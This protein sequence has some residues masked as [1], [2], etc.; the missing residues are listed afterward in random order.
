MELID[1]STEQTTATTD[2]ILAVIALIAAIYLKRIGKQKPW[3]ITLW[4]WAFYLFFLAAL[5]GAIVHGF[6]MSDE[7]SALLWHSLYLALGLFVAL[8]V[9]GCI[10]DIWGKFIAKRMLLIMLA[11]GVGFYVL[12]LI[13]SDSFIVFIIYE[14]IALFF[15]LCGYVWLSYKRRIE[16]ASLM[17]VGILITIVATGV[18]T[19]N[20]I[21]VDF[22]WRFDHNGV[23]H[24]I[25]MVGVI[26]IIL[27]LRVSILSSE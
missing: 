12:T 1:I 27:G 17:V 9:V 4:V 18:Q 8:F 22:V 15:A 13:W 25:Q 19:N 6:I 14:A 3:K 10:Y 2:A 7:L 26:F 11:I 24:L 16:G 23:Y 5:L 20:S 21:F